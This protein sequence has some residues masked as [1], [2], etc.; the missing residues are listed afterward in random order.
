MYVGLFVWK[1]MQPIWFLGISISLSENYTV[2]TEMKYSAWRAGKLLPSFCAVLFCSIHIM[3]LVFW[4]AH[5]HSMQQ[6]VPFSFEGLYVHISIDHSLMYASFVSHIW[7]LNVLWNVVCQPNVAQHR[8]DFVKLM[9]TVIS[10][11]LF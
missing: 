1:I 2:V 7:V 3:F 9:N 10:F 4:T 5:W 11:V 6:L 8:T